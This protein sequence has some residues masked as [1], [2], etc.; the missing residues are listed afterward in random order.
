MLESRIPLADHKRLRRV[1]EML[2]SE[3]VQ[4]RYPRVICDLVESVYQVD[5]PAP[6][7][8]ITKLLLRAKKEHGVTW[9]MLLRDAWKGY[10]SYG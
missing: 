5:N 10:R 9:R 6:K 4:F 2:L 1:P 7:P 3:D 8:G